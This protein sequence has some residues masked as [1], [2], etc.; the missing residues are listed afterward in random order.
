MPMPISHG[1]NG[2]TV[3]APRRKRASS[4]AQS[5]FVGFD[6]QRGLAPLLNR[7]LSKR[8]ESHL[9][10]VPRNGLTPLRRKVETGEAPT[11]DIPPMAGGDGGDTSESSMAQ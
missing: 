11:W 9:S 5:A 7:R 3:G 8:S 1:R 6:L 4:P 2:F 10:G